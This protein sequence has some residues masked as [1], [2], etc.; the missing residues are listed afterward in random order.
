MLIKNI[1]KNYYSIKIYEYLVNFRR[2]FKL[3]LF[4]VIS[5]TAFLP[6]FFVGSF[7]ISNSTAV[8]K[9]K[10][11]IANS[12]K[13]SR[14]E[15]II[16]H[17]IQSIKNNLHTISQI[18]EVKNLDKIKIQSILLE[19]AKSNPLIHSLL[20]AEIDGQVIYNTSGILNNIGNQEYFKKAAAGENSFSDL[21]ISDINGKPIEI[22]YAIPVK[23]GSQIVGVLV[24]NLDIKAISKIIESTD[25][26]NDHNIFIIDD[27]GRLIA[28]KGWDKIKDIYIYK[29]FPVINE[30]KNKKYGK[31]IYNF[32]GKQYLTVYSPM[33][34]LNWGI[35]NQ[36]PYSSAFHEVIIQQNFFTAIII[37]TFV[38]AL[39]VSFLLSTYITRPLIR[40][41]KLMNYI[42]HGNLEVKADKMLVKR[43][44]QF[45]NLA[46]TFNTMMDTINSL[47]YRD[48]ITGLPNRKSFGDRLSLEIKHFKD[49]NKKM[50]VL[51]LDLDNFK[52][53][54]DLYGH[55]VGD[56]L[57]REISDRLKKHLGRDILVARLSGDEFI[58]LFP[59]IPRK[60][61]IIISAQEIL[62]EIRRKMMIEGQHLRITASIGIAFYPDDGSDMQ[63]LLKN[64]DTAMHNAK[65]N[66]GNSFQLYDS[67]MTDLL[68]EQVKLGRDIYS[69]LDNQELLL[70][71]QPLI[72]INSKNVIGV[73]ALIRWN[74]PEYGIIS[75]AKFIPIAEDNGLIIPIEE[76]VLRKACAQNKEW[77]EKGLQPVFVSVNI[78]A[79]HFLQPNFISFIKGTLDDIEL[80]PKYLEIEIT[81]NTAME[82]VEYTIR[83]LAELK[84][85]GV[86][87]AIDDFG[88][89][90]SSLS[91]LTKFAFNTIKIDK[92]FVSD[93]FQNFNANAIV[94]SII[95]I[96][97]TLNLKVTAEGV[98]NEKQLDF[99][100]QHRCDRIQGYLFSAPVPPD[101]IE[102]LF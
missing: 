80:D 95:S 34:S 97:H 48:P 39:V 70:F 45:G 85:M 101:K 90:Y 50:A 102:L 31:G 11:Y 33:K 73:E 16:N 17:Y 26:V 67:E 63:S 78:S 24:A 41:T 38:A 14:V 93:L 57:L 83:A 40:L 44:D 8:L 9:E 15:D 12:E 37:L 27:N 51:H 1:F 28:H 60:E 71:Y 100:R 75:P 94:S 3:H 52:K 43:K 42:S 6:L 81:E 99:L 32:Q 21:K 58:L 25:T 89:G 61:S 96:G 82:D 47:T 5:I 22:S 7:I 53:I 91:Y 54:N 10:I 46:R 72:D 59:E 87:L 49:P 74:H 18:A 65:E 92:S 79:H 56:K 69:A 98:E 35:V 55:Q 4:L 64:S 68:F 88:T 77:Q 86:H 20:L 76:W 66:G 2:D 36:I 84:D 23:V 13:I 62:N 29:D 19:T 30:L